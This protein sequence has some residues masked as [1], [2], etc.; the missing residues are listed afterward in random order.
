MSYEKIYKLASCFKKISQ[1]VSTSDDVRGVLQTII[2]SSLESIFSKLQSEG[3]SLD[4]WQINASVD[5]MKNVKI[6]S[7][8]GGYSFKQALEEN[9]PKPLESM[10]GDKSV[11]ILK[12]MQKAKIKF[13]KLLSPLA[14]QVKNKLTNV[15]SEQLPVEYSPLFKGIT[16]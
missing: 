13:D 4:D 14:F 8:P 15:P 11:E 2:N 16:A 7:L 12:E 6:Y 3:V 1:Q 9:N 10:F 5:K